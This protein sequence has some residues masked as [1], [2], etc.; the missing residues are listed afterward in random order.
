MRDPSIYTA[1][2]ENF[3]LRQNISRGTPAAALVHFPAAVPD[4]KLR[5]GTPQATIRDA[6]HLRNP[7][8]WAINRKKEGRLHG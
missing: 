4:Q 2:R 7:G 1:Q 5:D 6:W 3:P 8:F